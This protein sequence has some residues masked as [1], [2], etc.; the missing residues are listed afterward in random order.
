MSSTPEFLSNLQASQLLNPRQWEQARAVAQR[1]PDPEVVAARLVGH[2]WITGWQAY[3]LLEGRTNFRVGAYQLCNLIQGDQPSVYRVRDASGD[4]LILKTVSKR[5]PEYP[6]WK[7]AW[8]RA[9]QQRGLWRHPHLVTLKDFQEDEQ[10]LYLVVRAVGGVPL[11]HWVQKEGPLEVP[12][13]CEI[14]S[15]IGLALHHL[16]GRGEIYG[17]L[18]PAKVMLRRDEKNNQLM[19]T[20][21]DSGLSLPSAEERQLVMTEEEAPSC[22]PYLPPEITGGK[23]D[24]QATPSVDIYGLGGLLYFSLTGKPLYP[25]PPSA[26][27]RQQEDSLPSLAAAGVRQGAELDPVLMKLLA[28]FPTHRFQT[29]PEVIQKISPFQ[30]EFASAD[31]SAILP[32]EG[33]QRAPNP[34]ESPQAYSNGMPP[35]EGSA[36]NPPENTYDPELTNLRV[37]GFP[38]APFDADALLQEGFELGS[39]LSATEVESKLRGLQA[40]QESTPEN[41]ATK[42]SEPAAKPVEPIEERPTELQQAP[43]VSQEQT[44]IP[45]DVAEPP[46]DSTFE[47]EPTAKNLDPSAPP[48]QTS[49][50]SLSSGSVPD[51]SDASEKNSQ[52]S[53]TADTEEEEVPETGDAGEKSGETLYD[54]GRAEVLASRT[55]AQPAEDSESEESGNEV[56]AE[57]EEPVSVTTPG[58]SSSLTKPPEPPFAQLEVR[59]FFANLTAAQ[60][61][62]ARELERL[63]LDLLDCPSVKEAINL[64]S[65]AGFLTEWQGEQLLDGEIDFRWGNYL[66]T[67]IYREDHLI[68]IYEARDPVDRPVLLKVLQ[69]GIADPEDHQGRLE[70]EGRL[71]TIL[72]HPGILR[73]T[74]Y[75][76]ENRGFYLELEAFP[77]GRPLE[78]FLENEKPLPIWWACAVALK[79]AEALQ[80]LEEN[81]LVHRNIGPH[82]LLVTP[83]EMSG[84]PTVKMHRLGFSDTERKELKGE[85]IT[86]TDEILGSPDHVSPEQLENTR[87]ADI[88]SDIYS[89]G[90]LLFQMIGGAVPFDGTSPLERMYARQREEAP[91]IRWL[92]AEV[93]GTLE[94]VLARMLARKPDDRFQNPKELITAL[95]PFATE[96]DFSSWRQYSVEFEEYLQKLLDTQILSS[97]QLNRARREVKETKNAPPFR[98]Q[99]VQLGFLSAWQVEQLEMGRTNFQVSRYRVLDC[100]T[101]N[102]RGQLYRADDQYG[103]KTALKCYPPPI[104]VDL[105]QIQPYL[106]GGGKSEAARHAHLVL[107]RDAGTYRSEPFEPISSW[108]LNEAP[109]QA[110]TSYLAM[111]YLR[112]HDLANWMQEL[113]RMPVPWA[114]EVMRQVALALD[115][116]E[117]H[118]ESHG[119]LS[120]RRILVAEQEI[121]QPPLVKILGF[122][123]WNLVSHP[124]EELENSEYASLQSNANYAAPEIWDAASR[125]MQHQ[126]ISADLYSLGV[127]LF[128]LISGKF[129]YQG[130][131]ALGRA[132]ARERY[133]PRTFSE[134][135]VHVPDP[136]QTLVSQLIE[137]DSTKRIRSP[138]E[139]AEALEEFSQ[140]WKQSTEEHAAQR[141]NREVPDTLEDFFEVLR[142]SDLFSPEELARAQRQT[143][144]AT[145]PQ[146]A[147]QILVEREWLTWWQARRLLAGRYQLIVSKYVL[148]SRISRTSTGTI[149]RARDP[150][151]R[152]LAIKVLSSV[153]K[154]NDELLERFRRE[155]RVAATLNHPHLAAVYDAGEED[156]QVYL[157]MEY[158]EGRNL[159]EWI[160]ESGTL[161]IGWSCECIRQAAVGLQHAF[162]HGVV[163]R[164]IRPEN[165]MVGKGD[166][167]VPPQ[168]KIHEL[169][170]AKVMNPDLSGSTLTQAGEI[171]GDLDYMAPEQAENPSQVDVRAD[172]YALGCILYQMLL[173]RL[174]FVGLSE[175]EKLAARKTQSPP[176]LKENRSDVPE[177]LEEIIFKLISAD[178]EKR[179]QKPEDLAEALA[180]FALQKMLGKESAANTAE[181]SPFQSLTIEGLCS[182]LDHYNLM[183]PEDL[184]KLKQALAEEDNPDPHSVIGQLVQEGQLTGWQQMQLI[185]G[186][187][188]FYLGKY[189]LLE[190][191][192]KG[193]SGSVYKG[194]DQKENLYALKVLSQEQEQ[195]EE[196]IARFHREARL[197][198]VL[199]HPNI[200]STNA[201]ARVGGRLCL[202]MEFVPGRDLTY[203]IDHYHKRGQ[204]LPIGWSCECVR[205]AALGLQHAYERGVVHRD[206]KPSNMLVLGEGPLQ[207]PVIKILDMG[208]GSAVREDLK[209][210][211]ITRAGELLGTPDYMAP[212]QVYS[213]QS[214]DIRADIYSLGCTLFHLLVDRVP[215]PVERGSAIA[216]LTIRLK[217]DAP[218]IRQFRRDIPEDLERLVAKLLDR[219]PQN[220][221][222]TPMEVVR[223]IEPFAAALAEELQRPGSSFTLGAQLAHA[224]KYESEMS[225]LQRLTER[226]NLEEPPQSEQV[227][228]DMSDEDEERGHIPLTDDEP[229]PAS[230]E[231]VDEEI[232]FDYHVKENAPTYGRGAPVSAPIQE[233]EEPFEFEEDPSSLRGRTYHEH[234]EAHE[235]ENEG[236]F[237]ASPEVENYMVTL[238]R[239]QLLD[240]EYFSQLLEEAQGMNNA[241]EV[242]RRGVQ[243]DLITPW[244][245]RQILEGRTD[246]FITSY[247]LLDVIGRG[248]TGT[249]YQAV[250]PTNEI[251]AL[252]VLA[253]ELLRNRDAVA[254]FE[255]EMRVAAALDHPHIVR[256][257]DASHSNES[258]FLA[259]EFIDGVDLKTWLAQQGPLPV[260]WACESIRQAAWGLQHAHEQG[261]IHRDVKPSNLL[262]IQPDLRTDPYIKISDLGFANAASLD[263]R[264]NRLTQE[265]QLL[266]TPDY[267]SPE[268]A[269]NPADVDIR[270]DI[271]SLGCTL[272]R[273][274][275]NRPLFPGNTPTEKLNARCR[276]EAPSIHSMRAD[277]PEEVNM[278][279]QGM[280]KQNP[281]ERFQTPQEVAEALEDYLHGVEIR[282]L[283]RSVRKQKKRKSS[284]LTIVPP[285]ASTLITLLVAA[286]LFSSS[287]LQAVLVVMMGIVFSIFWLMLRK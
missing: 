90:C 159:K 33:S 56:W 242:A 134:L 195:E 88:R 119:D 167:Q 94:T 218:P 172:L 227:E 149:F 92:R 14:L 232:S 184:F 116:L 281:D 28:A 104:V 155:G 187:H 58:H 15:Q 193:A 208:V 53:S 80:Y 192:G 162:E 135:K 179:Y 271:Y 230:E 233:A 48:S 284:A 248:A 226:R 161:P 225:E 166:L 286:F 68:R 269:R 125:G 128:Q 98:Q 144:R 165:I 112:G 263:M 268:Q 13:A 51:L 194:S 37:E 31:A 46:T 189:K 171:L 211:T 234:E 133:Y 55:P 190:L 121:G 244:Q 2:D 20:L 97:E 87:L 39:S 10:W 127:L 103:R 41:S 4:F 34:H 267:M 71:G 23:P 57:E 110:Q 132:T 169:G 204:R 223:L 235:Q 130:E 259:M 148:L 186:N 73:A 32:P 7:K 143:E 85:A 11:G 219:E 260:H 253:P 69:P 75:G 93:P 81:G 247:F 154:Q 49:L 173:G 279:L 54:P 188:E 43:E 5:A 129:P 224:E 70:R 275:T 272:H 99:L 205:Q 254:R 35:I 213:P 178:P 22:W 60:I 202:V 229:T 84:D 163:H 27:T 170:L 239:S 100:L 141:S 72:Q 231:F 252:K 265:N 238:E 181:T 243:L 52:P 138:R 174:P 9:W 44:S 115:H 180:P 283:P 158:V 140:G 273:L 199:S 131:S 203:W 36:A 96:H 77:T 157:V 91:D 164:N 282:S 177:K 79:A 76:T 16:H 62:P 142:K 30:V 12:I 280:L 63:K 126:S 285:L 123:Y 111:E 241:R 210:A 26:I 65:K 1:E 274:L 89:L 114:C 221:P 18:S 153:S 152:I 258:P 214:A 66:L 201:A 261:I 256:A 145:N 264:K 156:Q 222:Q 262:V 19:A 183:T 251:V 257:L 146:E 137:K 216:K 61:L 95:A 206:I 236:V 278:I 6:Y 150:L 191:I 237:F 255:R 136:L 175:M 207:P 220:R 42:L 245:A 107:L 124:Q 277:V 185:T 276:D 25:G 147:A 29:V 250:S 83:P 266:G 38:E 118:G 240:E 82:S 270:S 287:P 40:K 168:V 101:D 209:G 117:R 113:G 67:G 200:V 102:S 3:Q 59:R 50:P 45:S 120:M 215:Y 249:V 106:P 246:F 47:T 182:T 196:T 151:G 160:D 109:A 105:N 78:S 64:V 217:E 198:S 228:L 86:R 21:L 17:R 212:E 108:R 8:G 139:V 74:R 176:S 197:A 24:A 122:G